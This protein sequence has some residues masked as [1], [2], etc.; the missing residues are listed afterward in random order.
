MPARS[1]PPDLP[2]RVSTPAPTKETYDDSRMDPERL[3]HHPAE[4]GFSAWFPMETTQFAILFF[5]RV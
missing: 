1:D 5:F 4:D 2:A 3:T